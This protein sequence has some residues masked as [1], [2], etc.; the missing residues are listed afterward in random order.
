MSN[1]VNIKGKTILIGNCKFMPTLPNPETLKSIDLQILAC[2]DCASVP[3][4]SPWNGGAIY[5]VGA[6]VTHDG[7][8]WRCLHYAPAGAGPFGGYLDGT[9]PGHEGITYW[10][11][12]I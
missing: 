4:S 10:E 7:K 8:T 12:V 1:L 3:I 9:A 5:N 11:E 2:I 6:L